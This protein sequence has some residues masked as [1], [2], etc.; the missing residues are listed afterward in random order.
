MGYYNRDLIEMCEKARRRGWKEVAELGKK[1]DA[2]QAACP[3]PKEDRKIRVVPRDW[4][5][6]KAGG[7]QEI[8]LRCSKLIKY[9]PPHEARRV[10]R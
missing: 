10:R 2:S 1:V 9:T 5:K 6:Y 7:T 3:H 4:K 8:C